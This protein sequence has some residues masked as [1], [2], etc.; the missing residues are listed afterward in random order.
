[1]IRYAKPECVT[2]LDW[3]DRTGSS[4]Y[5]PYRYTTEYQY[6]CYVHMP[7]ITLNS[8]WSTKMDNVKIED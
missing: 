4:R 5:A 1:M 3:T 8:Y 2:E 6:L 7:D